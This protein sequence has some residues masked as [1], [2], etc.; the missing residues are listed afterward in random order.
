MKPM[1]EGCTL[2]SALQRAT[3][4]AL[5]C[6][7]LE[8]IESAL[9]VIEDAHVR[10]LVR[11]LSL[12]G[13]ARL[14]SRRARGVGAAPNP[15]LPFD[16]NLF[17]ADISPTHVALLNKFALIPQ[18][19]LIVTRRFEAQEALLRDAD[20]EALLA[21]LAQV[22]GLI[23]HNCGTAAGASQSH[24]HLQ[25]VPLPLEGIGPPTPIDAV[26]ESVQAQTGILTVP[27][28][29]FPHALAWLEPAL[30]EHGSDS[31]PHLA[32]LYS[33]L[34]RR[35]GIHAIERNGQQHRSAPWNLLV[36]RRWILAVPR[37][38]ED[39]QGVPIN[40]LGFAGSLFV[41]DERQFETI[42]GAGPM[43][44]LTAVSG[45]QSARGA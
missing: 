34:R 35:I 14:D 21:C 16:S 37:Q 43:A 12:L 31:V 27:G 7:A 45:L 41:R 36:T 15:F 8:P 1:L 39:F 28:L 26:I 42:A 38:R 33:Q 6:G 24:R 32:S 13:R 11:Q 25:M 9:H 4:H 30:F 44:A 40:A 22:D 10:F 19:M 2:K 18:H 23:F 29:T 3:Q 20:F 5:A 17:V